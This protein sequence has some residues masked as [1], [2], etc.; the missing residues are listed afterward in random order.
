MLPWIVLDS[1]PVPG[2]THEL[3]LMRRG[4]EYSIRLANTELM[5]TRLS[6]SEEALATL[7]ADRLRGRKAPHLLI[8]GLG[9]GFTLRAALTAH[10]ESARLT[11][12][13]L[14]PAVIAWAKGPLSPVF[15]TC[16][17]DPRVTVIEGDVRTLISTADSEYDAILLDV[18][19][20]PEGLT[21]SS[22]SALYSVSGLERARRAL[23]RGGILGVWSAGPDPRFTQRLAAAG[24][25][26]EE[27]RV[28]ASGKSR[29]GFH[30]LW[31]GVK[32]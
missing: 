2:E 23:R 25:Q 11:V 31:L 4:D 19:N 14:V 10:D 3:K 16:L 5:N 6:G 12:A 26:V 17:S 22:N 20:G 9:M 30:V 15:G 18:D 13:E 29:G 27:Q 7:T 8:G 21:R 28:R 32:R 24:F 1:S